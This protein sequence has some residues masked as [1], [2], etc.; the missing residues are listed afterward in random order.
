MCKKKRMIISIISIVLVVAIGVTAGVLLYK[1]WPDVI[2]DFEPKS[3]DTLRI[4]SFNIRCTNVGRDTWED[5]IGIVTDTMVNSKADSIGVQEATPEWMATLK[6]TLTDYDY[7]GVARDDGKNQGEYS[8][9]FYL[10]DKYNL[11]DSG[12][13]WLSETPEKPSLGWD[14]ACIRICTWAVLEN[15]ET[16][17]QYVHVNSHFD[18]EG[19]KAR[20]E[21]VK[22]ILAH[23]EEYKDLPVVFTADMNVVEGSDN[24]VQFTKVLHDTKYQAKDTMDYLTYHDTK[25]SKHEDEIIDYVMVNDN[26]NALTYKVVTAG[27]DE[28]YV[29]DHF[30]VYADLEMK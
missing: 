2:E 4:M 16:K 10:K 15:K 12:N 23:I 25:P 7:V 14:A 5:R 1:D 6:E 29:S 18:H 19:I 20:E 3:E 24:Y 27:V 22:M 13:F 8:A 11:V 9:V 30:P 28:R 26:F 21:S 17:E